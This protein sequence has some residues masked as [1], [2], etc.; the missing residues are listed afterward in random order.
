MVKPDAKLVIT[1][2]KAAPASGQ[3]EELAKA[4]FGDKLT[5]E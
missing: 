4:L 2:A 1:T 3:A 5:I